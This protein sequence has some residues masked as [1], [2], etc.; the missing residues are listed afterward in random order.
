LFAFSSRP[1]I[2]TVPLASN[3]AAIPAGEPCIPCWQRGPYFQARPADVPADAPPPTEAAAATAEEESDLIVEAESKAALEALELG[4]SSE[5][6]FDL[7]R[8]EEEL[9][10]ASLAHPPTTGFPTDRPSPDLSPQRI[11]RTEGSTPATPL[12]RQI[13]GP[14]RD[15]VLKQGAFPSRFRTPEDLFSA[16]HLIR[17]HASPPLAGMRWHAKGPTKVRVS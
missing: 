1:N 7:D 6:S 5:A 12:V 3:V 11:L 13:S 16:E 8:E 14:Y 17:W 10:T 2:N 15:H 4:E 9:L